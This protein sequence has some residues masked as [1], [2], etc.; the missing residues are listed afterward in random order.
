MKIDLEDASPKKV[1]GN[2][3]DTTSVTIGVDLG[4]TKT[5]VGVLAGDGRILRLDVRPTP[6]CAGAEAILHQMASQVKEALSFCVRDGLLVKGIGVATPGLVDYENFSVRWA[7]ASLVGWSGTPVRRLLEDACSVPVIVENDANCAALAE[8]IYGVS[9]GCSDVVYI[10]VGTG[11]GAGIIAGNRLVRGS[12][13]GGGGVGHLSID[14]NGA[15]CYCG[16]RGCVELY[17]SGSAIARMYSEGQ[18]SETNRGNP[19]GAKY[20]VEQARKGDKI[21]RGV[22]E[23]AGRSLGLLI[24]SLSALLDPELVVLGGGVSNAGDLIMNVIREVIRERIPIPLRDHFTVMMGQ[25]K[26]AGV[27]GAGW[28]AHQHFGGTE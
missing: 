5:A 15:R 4:G 27:V 21:A 8:H 3:T 20:V 25:V 23:S 11:I 18:A 24:V 7:T 10:A 1:L 2:T 13:G 6:G 28:L 17:A 22:L 16:N 12:L 9:A 19:V 26:N 14:P